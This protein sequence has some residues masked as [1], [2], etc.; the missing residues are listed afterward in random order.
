MARNMLTDEHWF[1]LINILPQI[2]IYLTPDLRNSIEGILYRMRTGAPW[3]D[4]PERFG[5]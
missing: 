5:N 4:L 2:G 1:K 3:R